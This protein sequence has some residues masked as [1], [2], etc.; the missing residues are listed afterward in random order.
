MRVHGWAAL[1]SERASCGVASSDTRGCTS[2]VGLV[3]SFRMKMKEATWV[4]SLGIYDFKAP[5]TKQKNMILRPPIQSKELLILKLLVMTP[6][7]LA[8]TRLNL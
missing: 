2:L 6:R 4:L 3:V 7:N 1:V 5:R 8:D